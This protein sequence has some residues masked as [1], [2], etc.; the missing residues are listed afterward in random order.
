MNATDARVRAA[1]PGAGHDQVQGR[2]EVAENGTISVPIVGGTGKFTGAKGVLLIGPGDLTSVNT[3]R[4]SSRRGRRRLTLARASGRDGFVERLAGARIG[5]T[6][7]FYATARG[8][9]SCASGS[10]ATSTSARRADPARRRGARLPRHAR[11]RHPAHLRAAA[12]G[13]GPGR[14]DGDGRA[15][16]ARRARPRRRRAALERRADASRRRGAR[17]A[18]RPA[19]EIEAG[20]P[21]ARELARGPAASCPVGARRA[22]GARRRVRAPSRARR[23]APSSARG[24]RAPLLGVS[25]ALGRNAIVLAAGLVCLSGMVQLAVALGTVTLVAVTGLEGILGLGPAVFLIAG[26]LAVGPAGRISDRVGRM[27]V[28][29]AGFVLRH[30]RAGDH[31]ARLLVELRR[32]RL[33]RARR[34]AARRRRS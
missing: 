21:F 1:R 28:I 22:R 33:P 8:R 9:R 26:A 20:L 4:L 32:A 31:R 3:Y 24:L 23:R 27:P 14:G 29:R 6:F 10:R 2:D 30:R 15:R 13:R 16:R 25:A 11:V 18:A 5:A 17:T 34:S 19:A 12:D 7:N